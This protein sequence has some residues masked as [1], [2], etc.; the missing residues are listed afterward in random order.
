M[1]PTKP[2]PR[3]AASRRA[4]W[5]WWASKRPSLIGFFILASLF[6]RGSDIAPHFEEAAVA[7]RRAAI[8]SLCKIPALFVIGVARGQN[9]MDNDIIVLM[10]ILFAALEI[11]FYIS[12]AQT[13]LQPSSI[14]ESARMPHRLS[15][16]ISR[17]AQTVLH[18][19]P[20]SSS[21]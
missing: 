12:A 1:L 21:Y 11:I 4:P 16:T 13:F 19:F 3:N 2:T 9:T 18:R 20:I 10:A 8:L 5:A 7:S 6:G 17:F 15:E 14:S